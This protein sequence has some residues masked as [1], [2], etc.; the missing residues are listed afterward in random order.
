MNYFTHLKLNWQVAFHS[1]NDFC[2][3][4]I[5]GIIPCVSW[6]HAHDSKSLT[7][8]ENKAYD[9]VLKSIC[10]KTGRTFFD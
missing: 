2:E 8:E 6:K 7:D 3:H 9:I 10:R 1:L 4:F 5:H